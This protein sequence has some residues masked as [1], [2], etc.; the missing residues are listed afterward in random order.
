MEDNTMSQEKDDANQILVQFTDDELIYLSRHSLSSG[1]CSQQN[2]EERYEE[3]QDSQGYDQNNVLNY[4]SYQE[5]FISNQHI[6]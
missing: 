2:D 3:E 1:I 6:S 5:S 4:S